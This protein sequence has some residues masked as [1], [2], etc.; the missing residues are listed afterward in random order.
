MDNLVKLALSLLAIGAI[1]AL[2]YTCAG[3]APRG[4][5]DVPAATQ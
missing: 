1:T 4:T 2:L 5:G 3:N